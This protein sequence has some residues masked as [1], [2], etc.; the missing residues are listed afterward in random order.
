MAPNWSASTQTRLGS[1]PVPQTSNKVKFKIR[2]EAFLADS[3]MVQLLPF[4]IRYRT[5]RS[6]R[7][8]TH[9]LR[10]AVVLGKLTVP[11][12]SRICLPTTEND[13]SLL[14]SQDLATGPYPKPSE[15]SPHTHI[16]FL[17]NPF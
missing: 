12:L 6:T 17:Y 5:Q 16:L 2:L 15:S 9:Q 14:C 13:G 7:H 11:H 10:E 3:H 1:N 8:T 4:S